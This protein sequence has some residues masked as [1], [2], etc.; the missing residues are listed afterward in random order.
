MG[1]V[2]RQPAAAQPAD[3]PQC[4]QRHQRQGDQTDE[5]ILAAAHPLPQVS[6]EMMLS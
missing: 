2:E 5:Q 4:D 6:S 3:D 1:A